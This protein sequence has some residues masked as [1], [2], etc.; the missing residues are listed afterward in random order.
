MRNSIPVCERE[1]GG[2]RHFTPNGKDTPEKMSRRD[3]RLCWFPELC[4]EQGRRLD[5]PDRSLNTMA[6]HEFNRLQN[7]DDAGAVVSTGEFARRGIVGGTEFFSQRDGSLDVE[8]TIGGVL[9][10]GLAFK[11]SKAGKIICL[12]LELIGDFRI[13]MGRS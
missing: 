4:D 5:P 2:P 13:E 10:I 3:N 1:R 6:L 12:P 9:R 7:V 11:E 8:L